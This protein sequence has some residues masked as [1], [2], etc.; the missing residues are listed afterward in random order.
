[1][2]GSGKSKGNPWR[3]YPLMGRRVEISGTAM[4]RCLVAVMG[5]CVCLLVSGTGYAATIPVGAAH[6]IT[7]IKRALEIAA[8]GDTIRVH[9]GTYREGNLEIRKSI[10]LTGVGNPVIDAEKQHEPFSVFAPHV[11]ISGFT[12]RAS[13]QSSIKDIAAIKIYETHHVT[14]DDNI[15]D[16]NFFG[17]YVL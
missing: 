2:G 6:R 9:A 11:T 16:D 17:N 12:I 8:D 15:L 1:P 5:M 3:R 4:I 14:I 10:V 7:S 13:G